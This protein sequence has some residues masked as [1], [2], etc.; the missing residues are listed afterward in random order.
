MSTVTPMAN[1]GSTLGASIEVSPKQALENA[2]LPGLFPA[3]TLVYVTDVGTDPLETI[4]A[5]ARRLTDLGYQPVPHMPVRRIAS[6]DELQRRLGGLAEQAGAKNCLLIAGEAPKTMGPFNA[7]SEVL[8]TGLLDKFG[9]AAVGIAG[10]PEGNKEYPAGTEMAVLKRKADFAQLSDA[11]F[12]IVTQFGF[13]G[14]LFFNWAQSLAAE[15]IDLPVHLGVAGPAKLTTLIKF[16]AMCGV[17]NS[18][19]FLKK[20]ASAITALATSYSP[21][22]VAGELE[23]LI[24]AA[25]ASPIAQLHVFPFGGLKKASEWLHQ[26]GSWQQSS[27]AA[28][29]AAPSYS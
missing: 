4:F 10:H 19:Q 24:A 28:S 12:R 27:T 13:D 16:A 8:E 22:E 11:E 7:S 2:D 20:R 5:G 25:D 14:K 1:A 18:L 29:P 21:D 3:G 15:G 23:Q 26:R 17:G 9:Y 6:Q